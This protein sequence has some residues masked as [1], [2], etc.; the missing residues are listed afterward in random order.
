MPGKLLPRRAS[1]I[2]F[3]SR[4]ITLCRAWGL[5]P[6]RW[7]PNTACRLQKGL[8]G[9]GSW[10]TFTGSALSTGRRTATWKTVCTIR[11]CP[12]PLDNRNDRSSKRYRY[13]WTNGAS[14][15]GRMKDGE[16]GAT[17]SPRSITEKTEHA[18]SRAWMGILK[19]L[20]STCLCVCNSNQ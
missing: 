3:I 17:I 7:T 16:T 13:S 10:T 1:L 2:L 19:L 9:H 8:R 15:A 20:L 4:S 6:G 5:Y 11:G 12:I 14:S 18:K